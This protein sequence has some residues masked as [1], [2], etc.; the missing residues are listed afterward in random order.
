MFRDAQTYSIWN[1]EELPQQWKEF[2][3]YKRGDKTECSI[4]TGISLLPATYKI[5]SILLLLRL[6]PPYIDKII[7]DNQSTV[8][9][10]VFAFLFSLHKQQ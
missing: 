4:F 8:S 3:Y 7:E 1:K 5:L 10:L 9:L 2:Y 6:I